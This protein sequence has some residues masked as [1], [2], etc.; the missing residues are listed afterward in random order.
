MNRLLNTQNI[1]LG[2]LVFI[3]LIYIPVPEVMDYFYQP[4]VFGMLFFS[5]IYLYLIFRERN[6]IQK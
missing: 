6:H 2:A 4:K 5:L 3:P 1:T